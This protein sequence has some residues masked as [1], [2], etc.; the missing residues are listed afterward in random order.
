[1][2]KN[3]SGIAKKV[4]NIYERNI[5]ISH[6]LLKNPISLCQDHAFSIIDNKASLNSIRKV[7]AELDYVDWCRGRKFFMPVL[8]DY[9]ET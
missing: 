2:Y 7:C 9:W 4:G 8:H 1:M 3:I 6:S 5:I